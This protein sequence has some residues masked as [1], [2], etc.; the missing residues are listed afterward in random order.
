MMTSILKLT[1]I[2]QSTISYSCCSKN[3]LDAC[4]VS[5]AVLFCFVLFVCLF[6][7]LF[8]LCVKYLL[9]KSFV[10]NNLM[11]NTLQ[12][13]VRHSQVCQIGHGI[14]NLC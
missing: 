4:S 10:Q 3:V 1:I 11:H 7:C 8:D 2:M 12:H 13:V 6:V 9:R 5:C 14:S